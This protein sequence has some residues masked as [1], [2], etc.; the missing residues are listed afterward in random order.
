VNGVRVGRTIFAVTLMLVGPPLLLLLW[1]HLLRPTWQ[2]LE[3]IA[4]LA[5]GLMGLAGVVSAP[6]SNRVQA[7]VATAY[8]LIALFALPFLGLLAVCSTG[9]CL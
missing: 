7:V 6:W 8:I 2:G 3:G 1:A 5:A 9:D 4:L